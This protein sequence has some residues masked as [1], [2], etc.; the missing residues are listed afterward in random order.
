[1]NMNTG[2][3]KT[4]V[5]Q[6]QN[7]VYTQ[8]YYMLGHKEDAEDLTQDVFLRLWH[9]LDNVT[10]EAIKAWLMKVTR[11]LCLDQCR[12]RREYS[13]S[14]FD[15][16]EQQ[17]LLNRSYEHNNDP[18]ELVVHDELL[19]Q[20][21]ARLPE[22]LRSVLIMRDVQD[23]PYT[24]IAKTLDVPLNTVKV[25][26]HRGRKMLAQYVRMYAEQPVLAE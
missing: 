21:L 13:L 17:R 2:R 12:K 6:Y 1:M 26:V 11:N 5:H 14:E 25:Y 15:P 16:E 22:T 9:H 18:E 10:G 20:G 3:F 19:Q 8:A 4:I 24:L 23:L 7:L